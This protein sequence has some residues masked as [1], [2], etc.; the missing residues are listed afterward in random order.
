MGYICDAVSESD[1]QRDGAWLV[2]PVKK[3]NC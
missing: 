2:F 3:V 1:W